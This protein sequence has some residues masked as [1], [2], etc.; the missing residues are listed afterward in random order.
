[1][2]RTPACNLSKGLGCVGID[3]RRTPHDR[4]RK[5]NGNTAS[6]G[7]LYW[8]VTPGVVAKSDLAGTARK[9]FPG[10]TPLPITSLI[11]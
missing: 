10:A 7:T 3:R 11:T 9:D 6:S 5:S 8:Y 1:M 2:R 4:V